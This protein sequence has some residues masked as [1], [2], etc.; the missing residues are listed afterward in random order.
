MLY[1][2]KKSEPKMVGSAYLVTKK[3]FQPYKQRWQTLMATVHPEK[4]VRS[5]TA[6]SFVDARRRVTCE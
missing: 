6:F 4:V 2:D 3:F 1:M 5:G